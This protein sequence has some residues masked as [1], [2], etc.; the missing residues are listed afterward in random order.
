MEFHKLTRTQQRKN[1][2]KVLL[3]RGYTLDV[4][5]LGDFE[6]EPL[7][8]PYESERRFYVTR[9]NQSKTINMK[10]ILGV[11][12]MIDDEEI[13]Y[14]ILLVQMIIIMNLCLKF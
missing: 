9:L 1:S 13:D 8:K 14:K 4:C 10:F 5:V 2:M 12:P 7:I 3:S 11:Y 6:G